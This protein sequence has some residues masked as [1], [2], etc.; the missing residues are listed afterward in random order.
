MSIRIETV[1]QAPP[2]HC[3]CCKRHLGECM[4]W[5]NIGPGYMEHCEPSDHV[6]K[7]KRYFDP[8]SGAEIMDETFHA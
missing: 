7:A 6:V 8:L 1:M 4:C 5:T 2:T 3:P